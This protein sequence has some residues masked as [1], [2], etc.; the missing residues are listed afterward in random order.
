MRTSVF[1]DELCLEFASTLEW[2]HTRRADQLPTPASLGPWFAS[3][4]VGLRLEAL[5]EADLARAHE[6]R[7]AMYGLGVNAVLGK[8]FDV[9]DAAT[10]NRFAAAPPLRMGLAIDDTLSLSGDF[11][12]LLSSIARAGVEL[13]AGPHRLL[14][15]QCAE[16]E[17]TRLF[18]DHSRA[19]VRRWCGTMCG[20]R[21][22]SAAY[23][24]RKRKA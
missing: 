22:K 3:R 20:N 9:D 10:I 16:S 8:R 24:E 21:V 4:G 14:I 23:R 17:C 5:D 18:L 15:R 1:N 6:L 19:G 12:A 7:D 13:M 11:S 2:R